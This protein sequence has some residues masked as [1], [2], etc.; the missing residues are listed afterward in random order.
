MHRFSYGDLSL[1]Q[2]KDISHPTVWHMPPLSSGASKTKFGEF[3]KINMLDDNNIA[4]KK[5][6]VE[7]VNKK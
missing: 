7:N 3:F 4:T 5:V 1:N 2:A 6:C